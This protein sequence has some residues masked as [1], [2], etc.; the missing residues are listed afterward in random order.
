MDNE[1]K[2]PE[3]FTFSCNRLSIISSLSDIQVSANIQ[4]AS[5]VDVEKTY[6]LLV[7]EEVLLRL[8]NEVPELEAA[9]LKIINTLEDI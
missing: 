8:K 3:P 5:N 7:L 6:I 1:F 9:A 4:K 2:K